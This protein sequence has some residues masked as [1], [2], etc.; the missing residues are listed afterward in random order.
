MKYVSEL[1]DLLSA[2]KKDWTVVQLTRA[3]YL[4]KDKLNCFLFSMGCID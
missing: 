4:L 1:G 2:I 3:K